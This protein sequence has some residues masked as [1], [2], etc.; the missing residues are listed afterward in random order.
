MNQNQNKIKCPSCGHEQPAS[1]TFCGECGT[2][3]NDEAN[4]DS[5]SP[6]YY[7]DDGGRFR[8]VYPNLSFD[9]PLSLIDYIIMIFVFCIPVIGLIT[10][11]VW[12]V[13]PSI[14]T[15]R[16]N[17]ARASLILKV[18]GYIL[19]TILM[20]SLFTFFSQFYDEFMKE[21]NEVY[22][23]NFNMSVIMNFLRR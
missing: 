16:R 18:I 22:Y 10:A 23:S 5:L 2:K 1:S 7:Q 20:I 3:I 6:P 4:T 13:A 14:N 21:F 8:P 19:G 9:S 15:N 17:F 11:I 12:S